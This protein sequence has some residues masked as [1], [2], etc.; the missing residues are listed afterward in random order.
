M[1]IDEAKTKICPFMAKPLSEQR[2]Y[3]NWEFCIVGDCMAWQYT[4]ASG[5]ANIPNS[6]TEL[7]TDSG[8]CKRL[9]K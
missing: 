7:K 9:G 4:L 5:N 2:Q 1:T 6:D 3:D 8:Y